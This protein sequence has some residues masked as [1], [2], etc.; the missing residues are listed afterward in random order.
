MPYIINQEQIENAEWLSV[1]RFQE[2]FDKAAIPLCFV[3]KE[4]SMLN[5]NKQFENTFGYSREEVPTLEEWLELAYPDPDSRK[6]VTDAFSAELERAVETNTDFKPIEYNV[7]CKN[8][9]SRWFM[10]FCSFTGNDL[11]LTFI[12]ITERKRAE[13]SLRLSERRYRTLVENFP[14]FIARFDEE[15]RHLYVNPTITKA[16]DMPL[17]Q[18]IGKTL[19]ELPNAG[20]HEQI[21]TLINNV[22]EVFKRGIPNLA[23]A[24]WRTNRGKRYFEIRH[25]PEL[26]QQGKVCS[27]LGLTRDI[28]HRKE[29]EGKQQKLQSQ[30]ANALEFAHLGHWEYDV[31][32][33][34]FTFNDQFYKLFRTTAE[35]AGGYS[36]SSGEYYQRFIY[37]EDID[38]I[39]KEISKAI[40]ASDPNFRHQFEHRIVYADGEIGHINVRYV[41]VKGENGNTVKTYGVNQDISEHKNM[42]RQLRQAQKMESIGILAGGIAHDF[43]NILSS[44]IGFTELA[45]DDAPIGTELEE[46]LQEVYLAGLRAK[47]L[48]IQILAFAR[49]SDENRI[50]I[51][52]N[53]IIKEVLKFIRATIPTTIEIQQEIE[54]E[55][56]I[57]GNATQ[58]HQL[59]MNLCTNAAHAM[60]DSGGVMK[61]RMKDV[62]LD[63]KDALLCMMPGHYVEI[64]VS[65]TGVGIAPELIESIFIPYFTTKEPGEGTGMGLAVVH[66]IIESYGGKITVDSQ[67]GKGTT[68]TFYLPA[69][70]KRAAIQ[71]YK[72]DQMPSG[73]ECVLF[74]DD[75]AP[76]AKM[77]GKILKSFGY[78]VTTRTSSI[79]AMELF[80]AKP[81]YFDLVITDLT[82]PNMT[83]DKFAVELM[84]IRPDIPVIL[85]TGYSKTISDETASE[86]GIKAFVYKPIVKADMAK[87]VQKVLS[88]AK[89]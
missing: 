10:V 25:I 12:D 87:I 81:D 29:A 51:R 40:E 62:V 37:H 30:L 69:T 70:K 78:S 61:V 46:S 55:T 59:L 52:P 21:E 36:M 57:M 73:T 24:A 34:L 74:V 15:G 49:Q 43:N 38:S 39:E 35:Q 88:E 17:E 63:S 32:S 8:G 44:I 80:R 89:G 22:K 16:F 47:D 84:R 77:G 82:M 14:D 42:E 64:K 28:T 1:N 18:I 4:A 83:G 2:L 27:V 72:S 11:L 71:G 26:D 5:F 9:D 76:I 60:E 86:I 3:N 7:T 67:L 23:E 41:V 53:A 20:N 6:R 45:L 50:P 68:F 65:D 31:E 75:E 33:D 56:S 66:G 54:S 48:V 79:E 58:V 13:E 85:C 19:H